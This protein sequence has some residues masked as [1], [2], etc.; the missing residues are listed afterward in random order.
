MVRTRIWTLV[1]VLPLVIAAGGS[2]ASGHANGSGNVCSNT[3]KV[4]RTACAFD[5]GDNYRVA[6]AACM[7]I[8][9]P[10]ARASC[11]DDANTT[12]ADDRNSCGDVYNA[13]LA[14][15]DALGEAAYDPD[16]SPQNF[17]D[18]L[19]IGGSVSPN[20]YFPL[21]PGSQWKYKTS[22][23]N[24]DGDE[25]T[26]L[27]TTTVTNQTK[28][29]N[30]VTCVIVTDVVEVSDGSV[31]DTQD[32]FAQ[33]TEGNVW[34]CGEISQ[35]KETFEGDAPA[36][37]ELVG[38]EGSWKAGR[39]QAKPG[40]QM[41]AP[42]NLQVGTTYRQELLWVDAED[43][44]TV[45]ALDTNEPQP[46]VNGGT[47]TCEGLCVETRDFS[48]LEPDAN[49]HKY[50]KKGVGLMLEVDLTNNARNELISYTHP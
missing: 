20:P 11:F 19:Q 15:C 17:V 10:D 49:E 37:P 36:N 27:D 9:D 2:W 26:E 8:T 46:N 13:R 34:Y 4:L 47:F 39:D 5:T 43:V 42:Q 28:L 45:L 32:W 22:Y 16:F 24:E 29:I 41:F 6:T 33:D 3:A 12:R 7:N 38:I 21:I 25:I 50:Y 48:G 18:P 23:S 40:I 1:A 44:A 35:Q 31:E 30:G 14:V